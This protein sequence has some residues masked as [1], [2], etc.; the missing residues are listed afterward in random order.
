ML[1]I[2]VT[3][4]SGLVATELIHGLLAQGGA[5]VL[6][7]STHP[8]ALR[9]RYH[10]ETRISCLDLDSLEGAIHRVPIDVVVHCAFAR[11]ARG[12]DIASSLSYLERLLRMVGGGGARA[13]INISSQSVYGKSCTPPCTEGT[14]VD[15]DYLY[16]MGK[17]ASEQMTRIAFDGTG[18]RFTSV[19]LASVCENARFLNVFAKNALA[20]KPII[21]MGGSQVCSFIDVRDVVSGLMAVMRGIAGRP[22]AP[23]YN[24]GIGV[25]RTVGELA[26]DTARLC[27]ERYGITVEVVRKDGPEPFAVGMDASRFC[28]DFDWKPCYG[29]DDMIVSLLELNRG[30]V[31]PWSFQ[32]LYRG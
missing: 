14:P 11:S 10:G 7:V 9:E 31:V 20:D 26:D 25:G 28:T 2:A 19:R 15:P 29:Y 1:R 32:V 12:E 4:A 23:V 5:E 17:Y 6:A 18:I 8:D 3:G 24:L 13:F 16:A 22:V 27:K 21:V 30:G